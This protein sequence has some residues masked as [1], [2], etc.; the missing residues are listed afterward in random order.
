MDIR[1]DTVTKLQQ[2]PKAMFTFLCAQTFRRDQFEAH[3]KVWHYFVA[4]N[5]IVFVEFCSKATLSLTLA[6]LIGVSL[7]LS[8]IDYCFFL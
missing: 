6:V 4:F 7:L 2:K 1:M 3:C 5:C 8:N